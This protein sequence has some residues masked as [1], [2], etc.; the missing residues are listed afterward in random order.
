[1][2]RLLADVHDGAVVIGDFDGL[3]FGF[4]SDADER[5]TTSGNVTLQI[6]KR[7]FEEKSCQR[8]AM[9]GDHFDV[10]EIFEC[11]FFVGFE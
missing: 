1:M 10:G 9:T 7:R 4:A 5:R 6:I 3:D 8:A 11:R 2:S